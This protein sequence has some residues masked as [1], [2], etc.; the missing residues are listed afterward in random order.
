MIGKGISNIINGLDELPTII[1]NEPINE[2]RT[3][4]PTNV[5][6]ATKTTAAPTFTIREE[7]DDIQR[8]FM[9]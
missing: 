2:A 3:S 8:F 6:A 7:C 1:T 4:S 5:P 9:G